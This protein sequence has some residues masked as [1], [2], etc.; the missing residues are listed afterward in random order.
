MMGYT[1][2]LGMMG[3]SGVFGGLVMLAFWVF[4]IAG[5]VWLV[6]AVTRTQGGRTERGGNALAILSE[7]LARGDI[8]AE[9]Y[10]TRRAALEES[11]R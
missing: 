5:I 11:G 4:V 8:D 3:G 1:G 7:R 10:R 6:L 9:E 2:G